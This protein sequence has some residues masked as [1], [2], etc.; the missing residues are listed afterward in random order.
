MRVTLAQ[1]EAFYWVARLGKVGETAGQ[2]NIAQPTVSLRLRDLERS[3][4]ARLFEREGRRLQLTTDGAALFQHAEIILNEVG[5][6]QGPE[7]P[8]EISGTVRLGVSETFATAGLPSL[9][10]LL[11]EEYKAL[12]TELSVGPSRELIEALH[13]RR[14]DL[15]VVVNPA[16][17][18]RL[19][20]YPL[21]MQQS[22]WAAAPG[23]ALPRVI[24]PR[25]VHQLTILMN[26]SPSPNHRQTMSWFAAA[27]LEPLHVSFCNTV[28]SVLAHL[29]A[30]GIGISILPTKLI[31]AQLQAGTLVALQC[32][33]PIENAYLFVV[34]RAH[35]A[36]A[37]VAA[38][39][40]A[41]RRCVAQVDLLEA[42]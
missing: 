18:P 25:D 10:Q 21:G 31:E 5:K 34:H 38:V 9:L 1:L 39:V 37:T 41:V 11:T 32:R 35:E 24:T 40:G 20:M 27:G 8:D 13:E 42:V 17:D 23:T 4:G 6:I 16:E 28:P 29:V 36:S 19:K 14:L 26:P 22:T 15:A 33:P 7:T 30:A 3:V 12:R 2:L